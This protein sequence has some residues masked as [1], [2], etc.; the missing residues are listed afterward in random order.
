METSTRE[1]EINVFHALKPSL[2]EWKPHQGHSPLWAFSSLE[3]FLSGMETA[4]PLALGP[5]ASSLET[6]LSG[7]ETQHPECSLPAS[8]LLETF[9][10][11]METRDDAYNANHI[12]LP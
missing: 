2:V 7:M 4:I 11:G 3:T 5:L 10:S 9:L 1:R 6:F 8:E 12:V